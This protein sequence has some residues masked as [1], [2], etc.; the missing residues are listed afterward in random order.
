MKA[1]TLLATLSFIFLVV[2]QNSGNGQPPRPFN[3][4]DQSHGSFDH[5]NQPDFSQGPPNDFHSPRGH[6]HHHHHHYHHGPH[7]M[8][9]FKH[10]NEEEF[11]WNSEENCENTEHSFDHSEHHIGHRWHRYRRQNQFNFDDLDVLIASIEFDGGRFNEEDSFEELVVI[12]GDYG[13]RPHHH[14]YIH[15]DHHH[16]QQMED[17]ND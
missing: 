3:P 15:H 11:L 14:R 13:H 1:L 17:R 9:E 8:N 6:H 10:F 16:Q 7:H 5:Q 12:I 4:Q 2:A